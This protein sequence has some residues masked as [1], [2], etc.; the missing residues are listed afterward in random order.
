MNTKDDIRGTIGIV[1]TLQNT[2]PDPGL[3]PG[4]NSKLCRKCGHVHPLSDFNADKSAKDGLYSSCRLCKSNSRRTVVAPVSSNGKRRRP[5]QYADMAR[6]RSREFEDNIMVQ[7]SCSLCDNTFYVRKGN[8]ADKIC[9]TCRR[10]HNV[11]ADYAGSHIPDGRL[12]RN[13]RLAIPEDHLSG[14]FELAITEIIARHRQEFR[15]ILIVEAERAA[16]QASKR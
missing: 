10:T 4:K 12:E 3:T 1:S 9:G 14:I 5:D 15:D 13:K 2:H 6:E 16:A 11:P 8:Q 7:R